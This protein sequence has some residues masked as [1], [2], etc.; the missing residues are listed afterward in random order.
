MV[1]KIEAACKL[2]DLDFMGWATL[3]QFDEVVVRLQ[4]GDVKKDVTMS[5]N[6]M[7]VMDIEALA[8]QLKALFVGSSE[9]S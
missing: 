2:V 6:T 7:K 9:C 5:I 1:H 8:V 3:P 4:K